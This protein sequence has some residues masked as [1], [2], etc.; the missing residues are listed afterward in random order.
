[1][2][3]NG[4]GIFMFSFR[5]IDYYSMKNIIIKHHFFIFYACLSLNYIYSEFIEIKMNV[6]KK[7]S[8]S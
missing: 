2:H 6:Q 7:C 5:V 3:N 1:M 8:L 4:F